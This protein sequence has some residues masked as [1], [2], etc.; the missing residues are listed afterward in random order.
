M[1]L[2][3]N[4]QT[5]S[6]IAENYPL[7][8][9]RTKVYPFNTMRKFYLLIFV[10]TLFN[11]DLQA[12][13]ADRGTG[14]LR[15]YI[16]W[17]DWNGATIA[18]G[19]TRS[20]TSAE[21]LQITV[22]FSNVAGDGVEPD[23]MNTWYGAVLHTLYDFSQPDFRPALH[24]KA[25]STPMSF[26]MEV[27]VTRNGQP[28]PFTF[29]AGD[30][31]ASTM[32]ERT[33]F[34]TSGGPW[35]TIDFFKNT[36]QAVNPLTGCNTQT[37]HIADTYGDAVQMGQNPLVATFSDGLAPLRI[38]TTMYRSTVEGGMAVAFGILSPVDRGDLQGT[39]LFPQHAIQFTNVNE[40]AY[41]NPRPALVPQANLFLGNA[42]PDA[43]GNTGADDNMTGGDEDAVTI[44]PEYIN[45]TGTYTLLVPVTNLT[46]N[47]AYIKGWFDYNRDGTFTPDEGIEQTVPAMPG[48]ALSF[49]WTNLPAA[50]PTGVMT[51]FAFRFRV[52]SVQAAV[53]DPGGFAPDGEVEDYYR[54]IL[55][56]CLTTKVDAGQD[57]RICTGQ[58]AQLN[59]GGAI[60]YT[61]EQEGDLS[62]DVV[63]DP[64]ATPA[65]TKEY[66]VS[67]VHTN[68]CLSKDTVLVTVDPLP[69]LELGNN[70]PPICKGGYIE[71]TTTG[72]DNTVWTDAG[73]QTIGTG[74][75]FTYTPVSSTIIRAT[76]SENR[77][78]SQQTVTVPITVIEPPLT[79]VAKS[80]DLDCSTGRA[81]LLASGGRD[82]Q[83][84]DVE[85]NHLQTGRAIVVTP[86]ET[87]KYYVLVT[88][89]YG[90]QALD[91]T[92]VNVVKAGT[93]AHYEMPTAFTPN[94]DGRNDCFGIKFPGLVGKVDF[95]IYDRWG[96]LVFHTN[97]VT[98]C[99]DGTFKG[100]PCDVATFVYVLRIESE[101]GNVD[102]KGTVT[103]LR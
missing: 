77:C 43:D 1:F 3:F 62:S 80:N 24:S 26:D 99:W 15:P 71:F 57:I 19:F 50:L 92:T 33:D 8:E 20:F 32:T 12:Q 25:T 39:F 97:K 53:Q 22:A 101:C 5:L 52:S 59:A 89:D 85:G 100:V 63:P 56:P 17:F 91:S 66:R 18:N 40:C 36:N 78:N 90:C 96:N 14:A 75:Q 82:Y 74:N 10:C 67:A 38:S 86:Q 34:T 6:L 83:W 31:E 13:Y 65:A 54:P 84:M 81:T 60:G 16:W 4:F 48:G 70:I 55:Q 21:G 2:N 79:F 44:W 23:V 98:D 76:L 46:G 11:I 30:A 73:G 49:T 93:M 42:M 58:T 45:T 41:D 47:V 35:K 94:N 29:V 64:V 68:G 103:L 27:V 7:K 51:N 61:W 95:S 88:D 72:A 102:R 69:R 28:V 37:V 87:T 9:N